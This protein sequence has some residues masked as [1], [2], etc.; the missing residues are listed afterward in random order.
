[1]IVLLRVLDGGAAD[2][3]ITVRRFPFVVGRSA[4]AD[5]R[6]PQIGVWEAHFSL[7]AE[8][9]AGI[10]LAACQ[11]AITRVNG[12]EISETRLRPGDVI[13]AGGARLQFWLAAVRQK[14]LRGSE[15]LA[16]SALA[17]V[18]IAEVALAVNLPR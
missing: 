8:T 9:G 2:R 7:V 16:W 14:A 1:M 18:F 10:R 3:E 11:G 4:R 13:E 15:W 5:L 12:E 6:L 17:A